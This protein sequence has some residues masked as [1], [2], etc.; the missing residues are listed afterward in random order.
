MSK[1]VSVADILDSMEK[2]VYKVNMDGSFFG[3]WDGPKEKEVTNDTVACAIG[4]ASI[5][6]FGD[7]DF[8]HAVKLYDFLNTFYWDGEKG[9]RDFDSNFDNYDDQ[10]GISIA[11][12]NDKTRKTPKGIA[13]LVRQA[14]SREMLKKQLVIGEIDD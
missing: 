13:R 10:L 8:H 3:T 1:T 2:N 9:F 11:R 5:N 14:M 12:L 7:A 6:I 4:Q